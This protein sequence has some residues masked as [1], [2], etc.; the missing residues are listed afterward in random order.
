MNLSIYLPQLGYLARGYSYP[1]RVRSADHFTKNN[2]DD[3]NNVYY[4]SDNIQ[5]IAGG[6]FNTRWFA[7]SDLNW[8]DFIEVPK[9]DILAM[10]EVN[11]KGFTNLSIPTLSGTTYRNGTYQPLNWCAPCPINGGKVNGTGNSGDPNDTKKY[12]YKGFD[13]ADCIEYI[14]SLGLV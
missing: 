8:T 10:N 14:M 5:E 3:H 6:Q 4:Y 12:F 9:K 2:E 11:F 7:R 1:D 13:D